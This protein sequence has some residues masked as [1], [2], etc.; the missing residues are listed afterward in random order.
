MRSKTAIAALAASLSPC[1]VVPAC[2]VVAL[3]TVTAADAD[4]MFV[5]GGFETGNLT[6]WTA[7][8]TTSDLCCDV[9]NPPTGSLVA[10]GSN[11]GYPLPNN[12]APIS[13]N[14]SLYGDFD[15]GGPLHI[16]LT[17][18]FTKTGSYSSALLE[19]NWA[20]YASYSGDTRTLTASFS[21]GAL[22]S[23]A[24]AFN[25]PVNTSGAFSSSVSVDVDVASLLNSMPDGTVTFTLDRYVPR[26]YTGPAE[27]EADNFSL[28]TTPAAVPAPIVGAGLPG[29]LLAA[30]GM[31]GWRRRRTRQASA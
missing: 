5:N 27:F 25:L 26:N 7:S 1:R 3:L 31:L 15:G 16:F 4:Q 2:C 8:A 11:G 6:G 21:Q 18:T 17:T 9:R 23:I 28:V 12:G 29:L 19:F 14:Y 10:T 22:S 24:Y 30:L 20:A 13:G